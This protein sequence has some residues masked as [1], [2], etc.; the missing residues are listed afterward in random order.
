[1]LQSFKD[2]IDKPMRAG[3]RKASFRDAFFRI[4]EGILRYAA[5]DIG[6]WLSI[7]N[8]IVSMDLI[9]PSAAG[10]GEWVVKLDEDALA[11]APRWERREERE[12]VDLQGW[13]PVIVGPFGSTISPLLLYQQLRELRGTGA[14]NDDGE[15][16]PVQSMERAG[17]WLGLTAF[18]AVG[19]L[20]KVED[21]I[22]ETDTNA[23]HA[24]IL[25]RDA[26]GTDLGRELPIHHFRH[27]A[28]QETHLVLDLRGTP[29]PDVEAEPDRK[30]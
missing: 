22:F 2:L 5:L 16:S 11:G 27:M 15:E 3:D 17:K 29:A 10:D 1:M 30:L 25:D 8:I 12:E 28:D 20:G 7:D 13:P 21:F 9:E 4:D 19:E 23:I 26:P 18:D 24:V 14:G 6:G